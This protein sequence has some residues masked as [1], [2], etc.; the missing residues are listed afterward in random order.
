MFLQVIPPKSAIY[1][2]FSMSTI[3]FFLLLSII[4]KISFYVC[5]IPGRKIL[6][7]DFPCRFFRF[8]LSFAK[9]ERVF[10]VFSQNPYISSCLTVPASSSH[11]TL[12]ARLARSFAQSRIPFI[13]SSIVCDKGIIVV[14]T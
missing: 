10:C 12:L 8:I 11:L 9:L 14:I 2:S 1:S 5:S 6:T 7:P 13:C 3:C 4:H